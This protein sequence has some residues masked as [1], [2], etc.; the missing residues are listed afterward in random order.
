MRITKEKVK[1]AKWY[2][3][4]LPKEIFR[5]VKVIQRVTQ[6]VYEHCDLHDCLFEG[7]FYNFVLVNVTVEPQTEI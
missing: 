6:P 5:V 2:E 7:Q 4:K 1:F 3:K